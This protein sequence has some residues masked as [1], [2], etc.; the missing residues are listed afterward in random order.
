MSKYLCIITLC[1]ALAGA[2]SCRSEHFHIRGNITGLNDC[3]V[4]LKVYERALRTIDSTRMTDG[5]FVFDMPPILPDMVYVSFEGYEDF[6]VPVI[7]EDHNIYISG[8]FNYPDAM[9]VTGSPAN[10]DFSRLKDQVRWHEIQLGA[11][12]LELSREDWREQDSTERRRLERA[13]D[14]ISN[15]VATAQARFVR[16][17]PA[18]L[19]SAFLVARQLTDSTD[20]RTADSLIR[21]LD[22]TAVRSAFVDRLRRQRAYGR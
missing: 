5:R 15:L 3:E 9:E 16:A 1:V 6:F 10:E 22:T 21:Q 18:S 2:V 19:A 12:E 20:R 17:N 4:Y 11:V 7:I 8:N 13:R 14:S